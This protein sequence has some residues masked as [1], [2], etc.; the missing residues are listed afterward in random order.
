MIICFQNKDDPDPWLF[1]FEIYPINYYALKIQ[2]SD[3]IYWKTHQIYIQCIAKSKTRIIIIIKTFCHKKNTA[4][5]KS[6]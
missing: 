6:Q 5:Y 4:H 1:A 3:F 2:R